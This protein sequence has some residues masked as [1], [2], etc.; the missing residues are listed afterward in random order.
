[1]FNPSDIL[2][3]FAP[4]KTKLIILLLLFIPLSLVHAEDEIVAYK[5]TSQNG[6]PDNNIRKIEQDNLGYLYMRGRYG[7]Y[8]YDGY[9][10]HV[11]TDEEAKHAPKSESSSGNRPGSTF[12]DNLGNPMILLGNGDLLYTDRRTKQSTHI[13]IVSPSRYKLTDRLKC[14][15]ITDRHGLVWI[16]TNGDGHSV[17]RKPTLCRSFVTYS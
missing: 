14:M 7:I 6:L 9:R 4:M 15:V 10:F 16:S 13:H 8:K 2:S 11:L 17:C 12:K 5:L 1:M 3:I